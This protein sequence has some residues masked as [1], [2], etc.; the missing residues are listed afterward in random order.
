MGNCANSKYAVDEDHQLKKEKKPFLKINFGRKEKNK[1]TENGSVAKTAGD[2]NVEAQPKTEKEDIEFIDKEEAEKQ[3][4]QV[5]TEVKV[6]G[7]S[8][9]PKKE[10]TSYQTTIVKHTQKEG[11]ELLQH[12]RDEAF[13][14][15]QNLLKQ[16]TVTSTTTATSSPNKTPETS[17]VE[18]SEEVVK[19]I[20]DQV[21]TSVGSDRKDF[22]IELIDVGADLIKNDKVTSMNELQSTLE[23]KYPDKEPTDSNAELIRK[24]INA[25]TGFLTAK[26]TEA[27]SI[28]SNILANASSNVHGV[29]NETEKTTVKVT[30]TITEHVISDGKLKE[31]TRVVTSEPI[32]NVATTAEEFI[33]NI[34]NSDITIKTGTKISESNTVSTEKHEVVTDKTETQTESETIRQAEQVVNSAVHAAVEKVNEE[35]HNE[36]NEKTTVTLSTTTTTSTQ[37]NG[38]TEETIKIE[39]ENVVTTSTS[40]IVVNGNTDLDDVQSEFYQQ[41][42]KEAEEVAKK[43]SSESEVN[44]T[45]EASA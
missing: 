27:G 34:S 14:S 29:M 36:D 4:A 32:E 18:S 39:E 3:T 10:I 30:R 21:L 25:A 23:N 12:L 37:E 35:A 26:G 19:Q 45:V 6:E 33:K 44:T 28:L 16:V 8:D 24:V 17:T 5:T 40:K 1:A 38:V 15:L 2:T 13:K 42:K 43:V 41:G 9:D 20:K 31:I 7:D 11:D 22:I